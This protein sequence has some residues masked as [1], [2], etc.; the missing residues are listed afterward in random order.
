VREK[1]VRARKLRTRAQPRKK[2]AP[3][4]GLRKIQHSLTAMVETLA[5]LEA[6]VL[7]TR[8]PALKKKYVGPGKKLTRRR[9]KKERQP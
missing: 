2:K 7:E 5:R 6:S 9:I 1:K 3:Q 4:N 8:A